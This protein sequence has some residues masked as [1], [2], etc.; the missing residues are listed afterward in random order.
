[1]AD[2]VYDILFVCTGNSGRSI[3]AESMMRFFSKGR[4]NTFS[5]GSARKGAIN[6][7]AIDALRRADLPTDGLRSK[8]WNEFAQPGAPAMDFV[9][10]V[11]DQ[12][13]GE[14]P[15]TWPGAPMTSNWGVP[16]PAAT[17]G[18]EADIQQAFRT[19]R[20]L[21]QQRI[22]LLL[23]FDFNKLDR[24][25]MQSRLNAIGQQSAAESV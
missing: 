9:I 16:D 6:P 23:S 8:N 14:V 2:K 15:P 7:H 5:G 10:E 22:L 17:T 4:F 1:M 21:L 3:M 18:S 25:A 13:A 19:A 11:C 20:N 12:A 24:L